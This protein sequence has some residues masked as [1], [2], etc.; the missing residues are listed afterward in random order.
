MKRKREREIL[1]NY[2]ELLARNYEKMEP[3]EMSSSICEI[4]NSLNRTVDNSGR[5]KFAF[6][7]VNTIVCILI[8]AVN[9]LRRK[10]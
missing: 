9:L 4:Y 3:N 1:H 5:W 7:A 8:L 10:A 2:M 6:A